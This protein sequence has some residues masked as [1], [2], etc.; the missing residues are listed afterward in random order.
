MSLLMAGGAWQAGELLPRVEE[1]HRGNRRRMRSGVIW[2][3]ALP[4]LLFTVRTMTGSSKIA[5]LILWIIG[6]FLI[7]SF[8]VYVAYLDHDLKEILAQLRRNPDPTPT[9]DGEACKE[10]SRA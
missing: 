4:A 7:S 9:S 1:L 5:F 6:M 10:E 3:F 2:L 8:L